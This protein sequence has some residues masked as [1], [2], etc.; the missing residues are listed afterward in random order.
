MSPSRNWRQRVILKHQYGEVLHAY[1]ELPRVYAD[2]VA[3][4]IRTLLAFGWHD[5]G[6]N[7]GYPNYVADERQGGRAALAA[8]IR[9]IHAEGGKV[10]L[11]FNGRLID[12]ESAFY[13]QGGSRIAIK[14][15]RGNELTES[16]HLVGTARQCASLAVS[17]S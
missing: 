7:A 1:D 4:G 12:K 10:H 14:D 6:M 8:A 13:R 3:G 11:Y 9:K 17:R 2:G 16:Y 5:A 15:W